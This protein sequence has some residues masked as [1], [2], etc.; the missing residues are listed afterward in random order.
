[1]LLHPFLPFI[2]EEIYQKLPEELGKVA[3][4]N[5]SIVKA[6]YPEEKTE[7]KNPEAVADFSLLQ[8]L[9]RAVRT[10]RSEFTIPMEKDIKVAI[11][12]EKGYSTLKVFSR[13][14]QLISLLINSHDLH[15]SEE[16]PE[17]QGSIPVVGIGFEA[18]VY[19][20]DVIDTGK[21]LARLQK[22]RVKAAGQIDRS[23]KK[24]DNPTFLDKAP[25]EVIANEKSKLEEL[26]RRKE[27]IAGY[28]KDLA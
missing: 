5:F 14:R 16:E 28:I 17:R 19:I 18:F 12:T 21:E 26:E 15:I 10:L 24:L 22:E 13:E 7:R 4:M 6:A 2:T 8:E 11:K 1:R 23:G 27:K 9:V 3:N 20:K 25:P